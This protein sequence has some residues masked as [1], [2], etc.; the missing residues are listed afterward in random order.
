MV[1][2]SLTKYRIRQGDEARDRRDWPAARD[3]Y[4]AALRRQPFLT[5]IRVQY[6]HALK[7]S[8][9][10]QA[11]LAAY[12]QAEA[13][14]PDDADIHLQIAHALKLLGQRA[15]ALQHYRKA[16]ELDPACADA[17]REVA[18][19]RQVLRPAIPGL[20]THLRYVNI[21][22]TSICNASC[23]HCP[24]GKAE[25]GHVPRQ[26]M[27]MPLYHAI[28]D[29]IAQLGIPIARQISFGLFGDSLVDPHIVARTAYA[30]KLFPEVEIVLNTNGA[31]FHAER[32]GQLRAS[33][34]IL[35]LHCES[36]SE[37]TY[38][39]LMKPL[40]FS[41]V[42]PKYAQILAAFPGRVHVSV[43]VSRLNQQELPAIRR[44]FLENGARSV[45]FDPLSSRCAEDRGLFES[46]A[47]NPK[48]IRCGP[49]V[50]NDLIIDADGRVMIC[51]QDFQRIVPIGEMAA[52]TL[53]EVLA[54]PRREDVRAK[55]AARRHD[56]IATCSRC[57]GDLRA[58]K[59][60]VADAAGMMAT[61]AP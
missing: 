33:D 43:P 10:V 20:P 50:L 58:S 17:K 47:L 2:F 14:R 23:L 34:A 13:S 31:A 49:T 15:E 9:D 32:H 45:T 7:E 27:P 46:L 25:T 48:R 53:R 38:N 54:D 52:S 6:G 19:L 29:G 1:L 57:Y 26:H 41:R 35:S 44:W 16:C 24:T 55:L 56:E 40:R 36:L 37:E 3:A 60:P 18:Q 4:A 30:R 51:C 8:G 61:T 42:F 59:K 5:A 11:A 12:R 28:M 21:G 39:L 22:T